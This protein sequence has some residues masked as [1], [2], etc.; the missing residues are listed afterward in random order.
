MKINPLQRGSS[1]ATVSHNISKLR[2]E[3]YPQKQAV[4][5][6]LKTAGR[7]YYN[8][9]P[10]ALTKNQKI[11]LGVGGVA[12]LGVVIYAFW[13][14]KA[15]AN[16]A[17]QLQA[18][19]NYNI[20]LSAIN[21]GITLQPISVSDMQAGVDSDYGAGAITVNSITQ[22]DSTHLIINVTANQSTTL[23]TLGGG[24]R[25]TGNINISVTQA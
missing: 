18:G 13:P 22:P 10:I 2:H 17:P 8:E 9:N 1:N 12:V 16:N 25:D 19:K 3:G 14:K 4:A 23:S 6:A 24:T 21:P 7:S 15:S 5:I 20:T 11:A